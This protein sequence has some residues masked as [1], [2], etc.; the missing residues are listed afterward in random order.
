MNSTIN[1]SEDIGAFTCDR[2][3]DTDETTGDIS[4]EVV[5]L[6]PFCGSHTCTHWLSECTET[7]TGAAQAQCAIPLN[8]TPEDID[9]GN[10]V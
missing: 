3:G 2:G 10:H 1:A 9:V 5:V 6:G 4:G 7:A 8:T